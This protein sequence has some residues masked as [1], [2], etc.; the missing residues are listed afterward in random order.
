MMRAKIVAC[1]AVN[2]DVSEDTLRQYLL[3]RLPAWQLPREW[4]FVDSLAVNE[5]G[6]LSRVEWRKRYLEA[7][8]QRSF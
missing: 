4:W 2:R 3:N 8:R 1:L 6:K 7:V 5:R